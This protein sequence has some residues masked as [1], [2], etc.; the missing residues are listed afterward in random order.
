MYKTFST[1]ICGC[2][3]KSNQKYWMVS[4]CSKPKYNNL[5][6]LQH[7]YT[8][9]DIVPWTKRRIWDYQQGQMLYPDLW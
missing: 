8:G 4:V 5:L 3:K 9:A 6:N 2:H 7:Q 1:N